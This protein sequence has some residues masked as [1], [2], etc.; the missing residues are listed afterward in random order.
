MKN[1]DSPRRKVI[2]AELHPTANYQYF[3][4]TECGHVHI[5]SSMSGVPKTRRCCYCKWGTKTVASIFRQWKIMRRALL[6]IDDNVGLDNIRNQFIKD[7]E[8]D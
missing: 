5:A 8:N 1:S 2:Y 6:D 4:I 3:V 7:K